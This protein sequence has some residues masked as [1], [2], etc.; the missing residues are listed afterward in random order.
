[1]A[2]R[3]HP[4][5]L[6]DL[7]LLKAVR[8][9]VNEFSDRTGIQ[10]SYVVKEPVGT[11]PPDMS[12][13]VYR[14]IQ[15]CLSNISRHAQASQ[16]EIELICE[17]DGVSLSVRDNGVGFD[18]VRTDQMSEH[19]GLLSMRER[20]RMAKG[21]VRAGVGAHA[22]HADPGGY[23]ARCRSAQCVSRAS[24]WQ[25]ITPLSW[26]GF[27]VFLKTSMSWLVRLVM[28]TRFWL[29]RRLCTPDIV[30]LDV[31]MPLLNGID[32]A[33]QLK[34]ICPAAKI[35]IV[36]MHA[37]A[38]YVRSAFEAGASAYVLKRSAVD[39]LEQAISGHARGPFLHYAADH[40]R[41]GGRLFVH[42][43]GETERP[44]PAPAR[45]PAAPR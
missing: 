16:V 6:D 34:K 44:H 25:T 2:Y 35:I 33:A 1:M 36:T 38:E 29:P 11:L 21:I 9:L 12:I 26:R 45:S 5:I 7:G 22:R 20:V 40:E 30:I 19:L 23:S 18:T 42:S 24:C 28:G 31:S 37:D 15:E 4:S 32:A 41:A 3:F 13:C 10:S 14:V 39:E 27:A 8:R 43:L 17:N